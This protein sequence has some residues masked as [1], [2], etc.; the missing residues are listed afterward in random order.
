MLILFFSIGS[1]TANATFVKQKV[2]LLFLVLSVVLFIYLFY[3]FR[4]VDIF[5]NEPKTKR[6]MEKQKHVPK[7]SSKPRNAKISE[8]QD[9]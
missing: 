4:Q 1:S 9:F 2:W 6:L 3:L 8:I 5:L 7:P